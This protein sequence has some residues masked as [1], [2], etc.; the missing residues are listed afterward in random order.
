MAAVA[1]FNRANPGKAFKIRGVARRVD[2][3][4]AKAIQAEFGDQLEFVAG[5]MT[6]PEDLKRAFAGSSYLFAVTQFWDPASMGKEFEIGKEIA[7]AAKNAYASIFLARI[8]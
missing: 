2:T 1:S 8:F 3:D 4:A 5:D 7:N 6:K